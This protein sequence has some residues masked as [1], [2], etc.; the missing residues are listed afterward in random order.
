MDRCAP[1]STGRAKYQQRLARLERAATIRLVFELES[2]IQDRAW[3]IEFPL[4][5]GATSGVLPILRDRL[6]FD[7][8]RTPLDSPVTSIVFE[9]QETAPGRGAQRDFFNR[10]EEEAE[11]WEALVGRLERR[12]HHQKTASVRTF[13][14]VQVDR[15]LP[16]KNWRP[17][18]WDSRPGPPR[19]G[20]STSP[21]LSSLEAIRPSRLLKQPERL[22]LSKDGWL[23][24]R[25][26]RWLV[27]RD[28][29]TRDQRLGGGKLIFYGG[30]SLA[31]QRS[32][33]I[34][35]GGTVR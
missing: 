31:I 12:G 18:E 20:E 19:G 24:G 13:V 14:A 34:D 6:H 28:H 35:P 33:R 32:C 29:R 22:N 16:E 2:K 23:V 26:H 9:V 3:E 7:L 8:Q 21:A 25:R 30:S 1:H 17:A 11:A 4:P 27:Q 5:Q 15:H 10:T